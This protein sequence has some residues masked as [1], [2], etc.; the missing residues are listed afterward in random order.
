MYE[1]GSPFA[2]ASERFHPAIEAWGSVLSRPQPDVA[3]I[4]IGKRDVPTDVEPPIPLRVRG[5]DRPLIGMRVERVMDQH[6]I[7]RLPADLSLVPGELVAF[8]V[9]HPCTAFDRRRVLFV[10]DDD[11][12][13]VDAIGTLF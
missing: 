12:G 2:D 13:V 10:L 7:C 4:G 6:A 8:G 9:S 5:D 11:D 1:R 3:V